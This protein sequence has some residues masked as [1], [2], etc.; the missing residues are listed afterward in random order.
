MENYAE[1]KRKYDELL[2]KYNLLLEAFKNSTPNERMI[3]DNGANFNRDIKRNIFNGYQEYTEAPE[4][5]MF[6]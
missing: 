1:L 2:Q 4:E 6:D 3:C 5:F